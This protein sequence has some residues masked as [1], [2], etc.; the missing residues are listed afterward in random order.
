MTNVV[1]KIEYAFSSVLG[2]PSS[3]TVLETSPHSSLEMCGLNLKTNEHFSA[4]VFLSYN[5]TCLFSIPHSLVMYFEF[6]FF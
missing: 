4:N 3:Q 2:L 5:L 1:L 6:I